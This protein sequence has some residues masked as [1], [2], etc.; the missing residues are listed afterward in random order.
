[1]R[2][3]VDIGLNFMVLVVMVD[4]GGVLLFFVGLIVLLMMMWFIFYVCRFES[5]MRL[6]GV[7]G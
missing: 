2:F 7:F 6:V 4:V 3:V 1:M 5:K